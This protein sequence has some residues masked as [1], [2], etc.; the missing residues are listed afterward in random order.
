MTAWTDRAAWRG[1]WWARRALR[2][3]RRHLRRQGVNGLVV[4]PPP[5]LPPAAGRGVDAVLRR[6][7]GTCLE[8]AVVLQ[9]WRT[10]QGDRRE[11][12]IGVRPGD[13]FLAHAWLDGDADPVAAQFLELLR[14]PPQ[15][16]GR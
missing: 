3:S 10:A 11:V 14:L 12:V 15:E 4:P 5:A 6:V 7:P 13:D 8:R 16:A 1:A 9:A 2:S